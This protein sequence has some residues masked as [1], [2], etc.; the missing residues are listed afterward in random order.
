MALPVILQG[1]KFRVYISD[2]VT[3][4]DARFKFFCTSTNKT[5]QE[6]T[7]FE[8]V[9]LSD[10]LD[11]DQIPARSSRPTGTSWSVQLDGI[12]DPN[13]PVFGY[14]AA[15]YRART[16]VEIKV[17]EDVVGGSSYTGFVW[18]ESMQRAAAGAGNTTCALSLRGEGTLTYA[19]VA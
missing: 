2:G 13:Q 18:V 17:V 1:T 5:L 15:A 14:V 9:Y 19:T 7:N 6:Q 8:E 4:G 12:L 10:C 3:A 11:P 16:T